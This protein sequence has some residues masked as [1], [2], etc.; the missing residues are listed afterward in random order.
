MQLVVQNEASTVR[1]MAVVWAGHRALLIGEAM[2]MV[3]GIVG[4]VMEGI[5]MSC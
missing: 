3:A 2:S 1:R 4:V 5:N